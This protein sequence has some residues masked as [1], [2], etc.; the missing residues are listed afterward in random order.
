MNSQNSAVLSVRW[1]DYDINGR[2]YLSNKCY[3]EQ[4]EIFD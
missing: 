2:Q 4:F 3:Q 1:L